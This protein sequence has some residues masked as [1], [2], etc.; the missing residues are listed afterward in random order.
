MWENSKKP[1]LSNYFDVF[2]VFQSRFNVLDLGSFTV[3]NKMTNQNAQVEEIR[4]SI[5]K[6]QANVEDVKR[7]HSAILSAPQT[8]ERKWIIVEIKIFSS[9]YLVHLSGASSITI[10]ELKN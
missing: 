6:I 3:N 7:R 4:E 5:D 2:R 10:F 1:I 8:D 9:V